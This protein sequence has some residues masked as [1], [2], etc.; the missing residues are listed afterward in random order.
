[1]DSC[2]SFLVAYFVVVVAVYI[3]EVAV[4]APAEFLEDIR[5]THLSCTL[6]Y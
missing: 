2:H 3:Y 6:K 1:M 5:F 4:F